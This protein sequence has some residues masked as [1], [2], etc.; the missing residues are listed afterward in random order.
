MVEVAFSWK[1]IQVMYGSGACT[2]LVIG[3]FITGMALIVQFL[4]PGG[5]IYAY[6]SYLYLVGAH[7]ENNTATAGASISMHNCTGI[8][9]NI[10]AMGNNAEISGGAIYVG[11]GILL[12]IGN[13]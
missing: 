1:K 13:I 7:F 4:G 3:H 2:S 9:V 6:G 8:L 10:T 12:L 11:S 5:G